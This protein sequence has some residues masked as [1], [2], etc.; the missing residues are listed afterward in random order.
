M[1]SDVGTKCYTLSQKDSS[2]K[3]QACHGWSRCNDLCLVAGP[4]IQYSKH[5]T[6]VNKSRTYAITSAPA[7]TGSVFMPRIRLFLAQ[8]TNRAVKGQNV[9]KSNCYVLETDDTTV[10]YMFVVLNIRYQNDCYTDDNVQN[11]LI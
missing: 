5:Y 8:C 11:I 7:M 3:N 10:L 2:Y 1:Q 6:Y 4:D 9:G